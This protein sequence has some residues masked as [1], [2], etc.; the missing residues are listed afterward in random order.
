L[1]NEELKKGEWKMENGRRLKFGG[2][3]WDMVEN[4]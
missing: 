4:G 2:R 3:N 1:G